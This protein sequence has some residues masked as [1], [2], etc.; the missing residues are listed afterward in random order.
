MKK[1]KQIKKVVVIAKTKLQNIKGGI[2]IME[3]VGVL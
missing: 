3:D 1:L 2:I